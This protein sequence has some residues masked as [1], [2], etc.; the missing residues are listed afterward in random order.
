MNE[1]FATMHSVQIRSKVLGSILAWDLFGGS[2]HSRAGLK[3][4]LGK[5]LQMG[6]VHLGTHL[7]AGYSA[8]DDFLAQTVG[9][10]TQDGSIF[11]RERGPPDT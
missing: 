7:P 6:R 2:C 4:G 9:N 8:I 3:K 5:R 11:A 10:K 1:H